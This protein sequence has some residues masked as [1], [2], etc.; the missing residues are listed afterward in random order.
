MLAA[1]REWV[2]K[3]VFAGKGKLTSPLQLWWQPP[4]I[5]HTAAPVA[6]RYHLR[7]L[8][9]WMPRRMWKIEFKCPRCK[10]RLTSK[11]LYNRVRLV[12]DFTDYYYL[13]AEYMECREPECRS[14]FIAWDR[15]MLEQLPYGIRSRFPVALTYK[16]AS[17]K[18]IISILR[19]RTLGNSPTAIQHMVHEAHSAHWMDRHVQFLSNCQRYSSCLQSLRQDVPTF[20]KPAPIHNLPKMQWFLALYVR[21]VLSRLPDL[22]AY[23]TSTYGSIL[24]IDSTKKVTKKLAGADAGSASWATNVGNERGEIVQCVITA[25]E[26]MESLKKMAD[27][28]MDR[29]EAANQPHPLLLYTDRD[30]CAVDGP[31]RY[32]SL[33]DR[34][35]AL[36][37]R[38]DIWHFM[39]RLA[40]GVTTESHPLYGTF[41]S[42]LS[43][44]IFEWDEGDVDALLEAKRAELSNGGVPNPSEAAAKAAVTSKE[45]AK[46][47]RR[48][49]R[50]VDRTVNMIEALLLSLSDATDLLGVPL[51][52]EEMKNIWEDQKRH[53]GCIQD[54]HG[55]ALYTVTGHI[56]K[57]GKRLPVFRCARGSTSLESFHCH[58]VRFIPGT[59][60]SGLNFQAYLVDGIYRWNRDRSQAAVDTA[61]SP[62]RTYDLRQQERLDALSKAVYGESSL[63]HF[64]PPPQYTGEL[65]GV[66]Y[67]YDQS[68]GRLLPD[69]LDK[70]ID[71]GFEDDAMSVEVDVP[72]A[73]NDD[74]EDMTLPALEADSGESSD[75]T[76][77]DDDN[78]EGEVS[79]QL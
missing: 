66:A 71:E 28:I 77:G 79:N 10:E 78:E 21:D 48:R 34:W 51:L 14:T 58:L 15:R 5:D 56:E 54:P 64:R 6:D 49:T 41:L 61:E 74:V 45:L 53:V 40:F 70:A 37:V 33:F 27:G 19:G 39:R 4:Q 1:D 50:G 68:G 55:V 62:H 42:R 57:G 72:A 43:S 63:P 73:L 26:G 23:V 65:F 75:D 52:R 7:K 76:D 16:Y 2:G 60:A 38:L 46:H 11:G 59:S 36:L 31:G 17:D 12:L 35:P 20:D 13:A 24:K 3:S 67:L 25:S 32:Q 44:C 18:S 30:C 22:L 29:Y 47:C 69:D 8:F 9:L